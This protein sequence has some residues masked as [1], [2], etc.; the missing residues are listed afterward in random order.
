MMA[1]RISAVTCSTT[2]RASTRRRGPSGDDVTGV[3]SAAATVL[4]T[5]AANQ[6]DT[7][8]TPPGERS[9]TAEPVAPGVVTRHDGPRPRL[10]ARCASPIGDPA[11]DEFEI[12]LHE[13]GDA[14]DGRQHRKR[15]PVEQEVRRHPEHVLVAL[16][17]I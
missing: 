7:C 11:G 4:S 1:R 2:D 15:S 6:I 14:G 9:G 16:D 3:P 13:P 12:D 17:R 5:I 8:A 10:S